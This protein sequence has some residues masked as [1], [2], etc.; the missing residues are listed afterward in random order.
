MLQGMNGVIVP[1]GFGKRGVEGKEQQ[2]NSNRGIARRDR[3]TGDVFAIGEQIGAPVIVN[4][5]DHSWARRTPV[6]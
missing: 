3:D 2:R 5:L 1:G 6:A 4:Q